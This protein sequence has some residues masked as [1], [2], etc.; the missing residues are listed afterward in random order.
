MPPFRFCEISTCAFEKPRSHGYPKLFFFT[1]DDFVAATASPN[2]KLQKA[3]R[4][5][6]QQMPSKAIRNYQKSIVFKKRWNLATN[7]KVGS[8]NLSGRAIYFKDF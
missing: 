2:H 7:Q 1:V 6:P 5:R 8:S 4:Q 3:L